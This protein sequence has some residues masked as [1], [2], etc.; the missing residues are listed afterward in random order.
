MEK[1][2][3]EKQR[4]SDAARHRMQ[5]IKGSSCSESLIVIRLAVWKGTHSS[6]DLCTAAL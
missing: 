5:V 6:A 4:E 3:I 2:S 1:L